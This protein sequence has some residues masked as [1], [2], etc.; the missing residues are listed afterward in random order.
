MYN[1]KDI[2]FL[3]MLKTAGLIEEQDYKKAHEKMYDQFNKRH[4]DF[5]E[6]LRQKNA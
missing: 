2:D 6:Y 5:I 1:K 3:E 4:Q